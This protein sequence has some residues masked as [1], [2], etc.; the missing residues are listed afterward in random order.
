[1]LLFMDILIPLVVSINWDFES[2]KKYKRNLTIWRKKLK[3]RMADP[4]GVY[5]DPILYKNWIKP[6]NIHLN[7]IKV[8]MIYILFFIHKLDR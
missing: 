2:L 3:R 6:H 7:C 1:M 8:T 5:S 4:D